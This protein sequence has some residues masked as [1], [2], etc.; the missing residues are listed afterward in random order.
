MSLP[1]FRSASSKTHHQAQSKCGSPVWSGSPFR[2]S[3]V[4]LFLL[5]HKMFR[6]TTTAILRN[7]VETEILNPEASEFL[8]SM[9]RK[10][11]PR[12]QELLGRRRLRQQR[13]DAGQMPDFLP[14]TASI[15]E[16]NWKVAPIPY[17]LLDRRVEITGPVDRKMI[18]NALNSGANVFMADFEDANSPTW[19]NIW[20]VSQSAGCRSKA[21]SV[22][23][24]PKA[25]SYQLNGGNAAVLWCAPVAGIWMR[26][27][28]CRRPTDF[29]LALRLRTLLLSQR[30]R[31]D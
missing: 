6:M 21:K 30:T 4:C 29:C 17:D 26:G 31:P 2:P 9:A 20:R 8:I 18:I 1:V 11:E 28:Y 12:R 25:K 27:T 15:R 16:E 7:E 5:A 24:A 10:F 3:R 19:E 14:Q 13:I 22:S 23:P